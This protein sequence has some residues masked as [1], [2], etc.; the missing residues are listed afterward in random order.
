MIR[1]T[2]P[3][4]TINIKNPGDLDLRNAIEV[5][6]TIRQGQVELTKTG[7]DI[8]VAKASVS[9]CLTQN[10]SLRFKEGKAEAQINWT[11]MDG[12]GRKRGA[13]KWLPVNV[14]RQLLER[15]I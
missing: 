5:F 1:G 8:E 12:Q 13:T 2:T 14:D 4:D 15:V 6:V 3:T 11:Y 9:Y 7:E 10:E